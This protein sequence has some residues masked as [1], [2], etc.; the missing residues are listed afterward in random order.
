[1]R[2]INASLAC[3]Q[4]NLNGYSKML[5]IHRLQ[6]PQWWT[7]P[8]CRRR[9]PRSCASARTS[10]VAFLALATAQLHL[11]DLLFKPEMQSACISEMQCKII[12]CPSHIVMNTSMTYSAR[13]VEIRS[14]TTYLPNSKPYNNRPRSC[15]NTQKTGPPLWG[16]LGGNLLASS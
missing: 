10:S 12:P 4:G 15:E 1:M 5:S 9:S 8:L 2:L 6:A 3:T 7:S 14:Q 16:L 11:L 13:C